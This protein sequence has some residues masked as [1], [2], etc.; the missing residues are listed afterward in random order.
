MRLAEPGL[1]PDE[2]R[3]VRAGRRLGDGDRGRVGEAV[4]RTDDERVERVLLVQPCLGRLR[5]CRRGERLTARRL[6][7]GE[8]RPDLV[9]GGERLALLVH[10]VAVV[11]PVL[12]E[13]VRAAVGLGLADR[14][15]DRGA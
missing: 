7:A 14:W 10:L 13:Y 8:R 15:Q 2:Q 12:R 11:G 6:A 5:L 3:V 9:N 1:A 4:G